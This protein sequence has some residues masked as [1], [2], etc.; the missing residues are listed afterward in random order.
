[1]CSTESKI[2]LLPLIDVSKLSGYF[3]WSDSKGSLT[4]SFASLQGENFI[5]SLV[6]CITC[7]SSVSSE[8]IKVVAIVN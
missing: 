2:K 5:L 1:M 8:E 7:S 3:E 6:E 4:T